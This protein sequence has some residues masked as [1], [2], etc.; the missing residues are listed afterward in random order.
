MVE[1]FELRLVTNT[2]QDPISMDTTGRKG[3][4]KFIG[5]GPLKSHRILQP[6][7]VQGLVHIWGEFVRDQPDPGPRIRDSS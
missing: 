4:P 3:G 7:R 1:G 2:A 5:A 6:T